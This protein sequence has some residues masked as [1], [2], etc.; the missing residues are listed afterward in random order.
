MKRIGTAVKVVICTSS[1]DPSTLQR[2]GTA[3]ESVSIN[4]DILKAFMRTKAVESLAGAILYTGIFEFV[5]KAD[6]LGNI[7]NQLPIIG[8]VRQQV[9]LALK[10]TLDQTL[11]GQIKDFLGTNSR[12]AVEQMISFILEDSNK[13]QF[14]KSARR[15][16]DYVLSRPVNSLL[17]S[18]ELSNSLRDEVWA[19]IRQSAGTLSDE[20][21]FFEAFFDK[22]G[23]REIGEFLPDVPPTAKRVSSSQHAPLIAHWRVSSKSSA[24]ASLKTC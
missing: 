3:V 10:A 9:N 15:A 5:Q 22:M 11:G 1:L 4:R 7:V 12:P 6:I 23:D 18:K 20:E 24:Q 16:V 19:T 8:A 2:I 21:A 17:P 13:L 14:G